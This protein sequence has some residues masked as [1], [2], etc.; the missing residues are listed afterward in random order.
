MGSV[1]VLNSFSSVRIMKY[2]LQFIFY[3]CHFQTQLELDLKR[4]DYVEYCLWV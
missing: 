3:L 1:N 2:I 4:V